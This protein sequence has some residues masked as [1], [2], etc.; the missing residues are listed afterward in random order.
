MFISKRSE[1]LVFF[2]TVLSLLLIGILSLCLGRY[3]LKP[4][5]VFSVLANA[6]AGRASDP[7]HEGIV[8]YVR[9]PRILLGFLVGGSLAT[10]GAAFQ[11]VFRNPLVSSGMLGVSSG[12][13]FGAALAI[14]IFGRTPFIYPLSFF[15]GILAV[16]LSFFV[17]KY[18]RS[19]TRISLV[20]GGV[21]IGSLFSAMISFLKYVADPF[22]ELPAI[23]FWL[24]GSLAS[25]RYS[26]ILLAG[27][28]MIT[29]AFGLVVLGYR[30]NVLSMGDREARS[31]GIHV[32]MIRGLV[33]VFASLA[34]AGAVSVAGVIG[35]IGLIVPHMVRMVVGSDNR[36][37][38][39]LSFAAGGAILILVDDLA[40][41]LTGSE[42]PLGILTAFVGAP[43]FIYLLTRTKVK[44]W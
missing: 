40:R 1:R 23:V 33:I 36:K 12:A 38:V 30:I 25:A 17:G 9:L 11:G 29:G 22:E 19:E 31:M 24:M 15:F 26:D 37:V 3:P 6:L 41:L 34:S 42:M 13:G 2:L 18:T 16:V 43:F 4:A 7:V 44:G 14:V 20:L 21:V 27:I 10:S 5:E 39:P 8:L 35:W 28:P 32:N